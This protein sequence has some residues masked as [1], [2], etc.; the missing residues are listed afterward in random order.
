VR[1]RSTF[2]RPVPRESGVTG[3]SVDLGTAVRYSLPFLAIGILNL[4]TWR[5]SEVL[6]LGHFRTAAEAGYFD[7]AYRL[8]QMVLEFVP[9]AIWPLVMAGFAEVYTRD[10]G[11]LRRATDAYYKL[12][13]LLVAPLS[14]GGVLTGDL[15]VRLLYGGQYDLSGTVC[16][17]FFMV[18]ALSFIATPLSMVLYVL[19]R[20]GIGLAIYAVNAAINVG[21]D[22]L[23]IPRYGVWGAVIPVSLVIFLSPVPYLFVLRRLGADVEV[24][25]GF[26]A[27]VYGAS[28]VMFALWPLRAWVTGPW[29]LIGLTGAGVVL[30][31][32]GLRFLRVLGPA[33]QSLI[34]RANLPAWGLLAPVLVGRGSKEAR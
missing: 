4:I 27:R 14:I 19:E 9:G 34:E 1:L 17:V 2:A 13:F 23:L 15:A 11:A 7:L 30:Y 20:P 22:L 6:F 16:Q 29:S 25:W 24:P 26:L 5:Q 3:R 18:F 31:G 33:E 8:P 28:A 32:L 10:P 12:L 21:L